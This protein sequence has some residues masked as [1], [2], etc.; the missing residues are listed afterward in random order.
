[1]SKNESFIPDK[2]P[3]EDEDYFKTIKFT[4]SIFESKR[5]T[6]KTIKLYTEQAFPKDEEHKTLLIYCHGLHEHCSRYL[7][8]SAF[9][10]TSK[11]KFGCCLMDHEGHGRSE[12]LK[13][14][15]ESI[16]YLVEDVVN[17]TNYCIKKYKTEE[18]MKV[19]L[20][21]GSMG[22]LVALQ[23]IRKNPKLFDGVVLIAPLVDVSEDSKPNI[24]VY[25]I[26][27]LLNI[28]TPTLPL[29]EGNGGKN[30]TDEK[31]VTEFKNDNLNYNGKLR[32]SSGLAMSS[33]FTDLQKTLG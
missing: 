7:G 13:G 20:Q 1:M 19:F 23:L 29:I 32:V 18:N 26:G 2:H 27:Q 24:A 10:A 31:Y 30:N 15:F 28:I 8:Y 11:I 4:N 33:S 12:G 25:Y 6:G 14:Y 17:Y 9:L 21:A 3:K 5:K 22:G 16:D